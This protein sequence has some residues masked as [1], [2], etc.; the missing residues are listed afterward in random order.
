LNE[1][2]PERP[3]AVIAGINNGSNLGNDV[4]YS[5]TVAAA[6]EA[7][8]SGLAAVAVSLDRKAGDGGARWDTAGEIV[9]RVVRQVLQDGLPPG[10]FLNVNVP[11]LSLAD[12]K[13]LRAARV[14]R[15][16]YERRVEKRLDPRG[17]PYYWIGGTHLSYGEGDDVDGHLL[18]QG[19]AT[20]SPVHIDPT[21]CGALAGLKAWTD[22]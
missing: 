13:G 21:A 20:V 1:L 11:N 14:G 12:V 3:K 22:G 2:L 19:Y 15:R 5:G 10:V 18:V 7:C 9:R 6:R 17:F 4:H 8:L 16:V